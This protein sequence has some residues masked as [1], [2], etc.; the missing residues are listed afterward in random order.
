MSLKKAMFWLLVVGV[1]GG[2]MALL[3]LDNP[4]N[5]GWDDSLRQ[6]WSVLLLLTCLVAVVIDGF[7]VLALAR[8]SAMRFLALCQQGGSPMATPYRQNLD[9]ALPVCDVEPLRSL[10]RF[11][12][13]RRWRSKVRL[14][15][16]VGEP[17]QVQA[18]A[19]GLATDQWQEA[20]GVVLLHGGSVQTPDC[21]AWTLWR[22]LCR[23][24]PV[25]Q[26][27]WAVA[28]EHRAQ[29]AFLNNGLRELE[30][31]ARAWTWQA[32]V[33]LWV[34][35][36]EA[37]SEHSPDAGAVLDPC[38][39]A[40]RWAVTLQAQAT[41]LLKRSLLCLG[42]QRTQAGLYALGLSWH[43]R[44]GLAQQWCKALHDQ[45]PHLG[46]R[47][48]PIRGL[49]FSQP[50]P[51]DAH[52]QPNAWQRH[53][54]WARLLADRYPARRVGWVSARSARWAG[55][56]ALVVALGAVA[57]SWSGN[58]G[59]L[60]QAGQALA[61]NTLDSLLPV[62][63]TLTA[64]AAHGSPWHQRF[65]LDRST[66]VLQ[67]LWP[68]YTV[69]NQAELAGPTLAHLEAV[70]RDLDQWPAGALA[71]QVRAERGYE[72]LKAYLMLTDPQR[73]EPD[74]LQALGAS[75]Q[76][77][78]EAWAFYLQQLRAYPSLA[79]VRN[80]GLVRLARQRLLAELGQRNAEQNLYQAAMA[81]ALGSYPDLGLAQLAPNTDAALLYH[82]EQ[83]VPGQFTRQAW[84]GSVRQALAR[85]ARA[86]REQIDW[87]LAE[88]DGQAAPP[89]DADA[90]RRRLEAR[91]WRDYTQAWQRFLN[92]LRWRDTDTVEAVAIQL[93]LLSD[94]HASPLRAL[95]DNLTWH[96]EAGRE[97]AA[98][99]ESLLASAQEMIGKPVKVTGPPSG[100][101]DAAFGPLLAL[102]DAS[103][104]GPNLAGWF[105]QVARLRLRLQQI[106]SAADPQAVTQALAQ[107]V[108][109]GREADI[110]APRAYGQLLAASLG[111]PWS[112]AGQAL[113][114]Q[115]LE[116]AWQRLLQ[117]AAQG[118]NRQWREAVVAP[119]NSALSGRYPF[120]DTT[121]DASLAFLG[122]MIRADSGRIER[123]VQ[124][125]LAGVLRKQGNRWV[126][127]ADNSQGLRLNPA[128]LNALATLDRV[129]QVVFSDG[130]QGL[131]FELSGQPARDVVQSTLS[132][133][134]R[135]HHYFN[136]KPRWQRFTWPGRGDHAGAS[137]TWTSVRTGERLY[138]E[139][140]GTWG[141]IRLLEN[142]QATA[143][144]PDEGLHRLVIATPDGLSLAWQLRTELGGGP[145][146]LLALRG[147]RLP[148]EIFL[149]TPT[150]AA[151]DDT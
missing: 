35:Q 107:G 108:F 93:S 7:S 86:R 63:R 27:V 8:L 47:G 61:T 42:Q 73:L 147:L 15:L 129:A 104:S 43:L 123:F 4:L 81:E 14:V 21:Q 56:A 111:A 10:L 24:R 30:Q 57:A 68:F 19:P 144:T 44:Q 76:L 141:L 92:D 140:H 16:V 41:S 37:V 112:G 70:L 139:H 11:R 96:A 98:L 87:V 131:T 150:V 17:A 39:P 77:N 23:R 99:G 55:V 113:F 79:P 134:G 65:G 66:A 102:R 38:Q 75:Q 50:L 82:S 45:Q 97:R 13:G 148:S 9:Q 115:P 124:Q 71:R 103:A 62:T 34:I 52:C 114:A 64:H 22:A 28:A 60:S 127:D 94:A 88:P 149:P 48:V 143:L 83:T 130:N 72:A 2:G 5:A 117:P 53:G 26:I 151:G 133:D 109:Q 40:E 132:V 20:G 74:S 118:I 58:M 18:L 135:R 80:E 89:L 91:Y 100:P 1:S 51:R 33:H 106:S 54:S 6:R 3:W 69:A 137:L 128:F 119:W 95:F 116:Q 90:L 122:Q 29:V 136:H 85:T 36:G 59:L 84:E 125:E 110:V 146:A 105:T 25:D 12:H 67:R 31:R 49:W 101:L 138:A 126:V 121:T 142:A 78:P 32:P 46:G 120:A 145:L